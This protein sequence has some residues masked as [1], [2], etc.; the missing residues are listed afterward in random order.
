MSNVDRRLLCKLFIPALSIAIFQACFPFPEDEEKSGPDYGVYGLRRI[1]ARGMEF[2]QGSGGLLAAT[3]ETPAMTSSFTYDF[4]VDTAEVTQGEFRKLAER[5]PAAGSASGKGDD[6]PVFNVTWYDAV[7]FCNRRSREAGFD[8]VYEY[9]GA[10]RAPDGRVYA[11]ENLITHL[12]RVGFRLP[13]E[14]EWEYAARAGGQG[15]F[16]WGGSDDSVLAARHAWFLGNSENAPHPVGGLSPNGFGLHDMAGNVMEWVNDWK[17]PYP[18]GG[19]RDFA[20]ARNPGPSSEVP[21]KGGSFKNG[22]RGLRISARSSTYPAIPSSSSEYVGFRCALGAVANP[23]Y[24]SSDGATLQS[25]PVALRSGDLA[26]RAAKLVF[27]NSSHGNRYLDYVNYQFYP[28]RVQEFGSENNVFNPVLSPDGNWVA[29]GTA[30]EGIFQG[31]VIHLRK[32]DDANVTSV[33]IGGGFIPRWWVNPATLDTFL[34]YSNSAVDNTDFRWSSTQTLLQKIRAGKPEGA[35][36]TLTED[37]GFHDGL[38]RDGRYLATGYRRLRLRD[39]TAGTSRILFTAPQNGKADGDTSQVCNVSISPDSSGRT[40]FLDFGFDKRS[41][42][43]GG[44]YGVHEYAF[45]GDPAGNVLRWYRAPAGEDGWED[46]EWSNQSGFAVSAAKDPSGS[47]RHLYLVNL[48]DSSYAPLATGANLLEPGLWL[49]MGPQGLPPID[50]NL[51]LDSLGYYNE[52]LGNGAQPVFSDKMDK[53]WANH[54]SFELVATGS[55][56][57]QW[58]INPHMFT[59]WN[60]FNLGITGIFSSR[61]LAT[62]Y[63]LRHCPNLK[64]L[65]YEVFL[66]PMHMHPEAGLWDVVLGKSKGALY[67]E[68]HGYWKDGTP[69]NFEAAM[70]RA[71]HATIA[72]ID[73][74]GNFPGWDFGWGPTPPPEEFETPW[75]VDDSIYRENFRVL[76]DV[77]ALA[78]QKGVHIVFVNFPQNPAYKNTSIYQRSGP[79][80]N[81]A[82]SIIAQVKD[83]EKISP[84]VHFYDAYNFGNHD[85]TNEDAFDADHLSPKGAIKLSSRLDSLIGTFNIK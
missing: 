71:P 85:Y 44:A 74:T 31:S 18:A 62:E 40:L 58:G 53:F 69:L 35:P 1:P 24:A 12:D 21:V 2:T 22:W 55:S 66:G 37:G 10:S 79:D 33:T 70:A 36:L 32:V 64:V 67:D 48:K 78:V 84:K 76:E 27:V 19:G 52:P 5:D 65:I 42:L 17:G 3:D 72:G 13:T 26:G 46:L 45:V 63:V 15:D 8:T 68:S 11:L 50:I 28:P 29:Y 77:A 47:R 54:R 83:L 30:E 4:W 6:Y 23:S 25:E 41:A 57:A 7:L 82:R 9:G 20:G 81:T 60:S 80:W 56:H 34:V 59:H 61:I 39:R 49:G 75:T 43:I 38:S 16:I 51:N 73:S 14:A